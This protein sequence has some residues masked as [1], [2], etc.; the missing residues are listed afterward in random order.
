M[1]TVW[2]L[3]GNEE[4]AVRYLQGYGIIPQEKW[5]RYEHKM[6]ILFGSSIFWKC[7]NRNCNSRISIRTS[8]WLEGSRLPLVIVI[9]FI[10]MWSKSQ[11]SITNCKEELN[12]GKNAVIDY[13][14]YLRE[15]CVH[16]L[17]KHE[18]KIGGPGKCVEI[19]ESMYTRRKN[20][21]GRVLPQQW[22]FGG[23]FRE[24]NDC[25][26]VTV[27]DTSAATLFATI[28]KHI[29]VG[30]VIFSDCWK[31]YKSEELQAA[32]YNHMQ[33]NHKYITSWIQQRKRT[34]KISNGYGAV[35]NGISASEVQ[36]DICSSHILQNLCGSV[37]MAKKTTHF[38]TF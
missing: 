13:N 19:D 7:S 8:T 16:V 15:V 18:C 30:S 5:C 32:G 36:H 1:T 27:P 17:E 24:D 9:R 6:H 29:E 26:V 37:N 3:P 23:I 28:R 34:R 2:D 20:N 31:G 38:K 33:V 25:F 12:I 10:Y 22:I 14:N 21:C 4:D 35:Q 11:T